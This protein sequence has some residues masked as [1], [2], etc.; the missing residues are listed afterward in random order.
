[1]K[2]PASANAQARLTP[3]YETLE[4][5]RE[6]TQGARSWADLPDAQGGQGIRRGAAVMAAL[7]IRKRDRIQSSPKEGLRQ[8]W[9]EYQVVSG[10]RILSRH[11]SEGQALEWIRNHDTR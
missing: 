5:W 8:A 3:V 11:D 10:R 6:S 1:M 9:T 4:G 2:R 7:T